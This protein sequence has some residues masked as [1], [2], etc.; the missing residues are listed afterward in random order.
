M[1]TRTTVESTFL[2]ADSD[3]LTVSPGEERTPKASET[4][5][6][7]KLLGS[8]SGTTIPVK[9]PSSHRSSF[10][11]SVK[12]I[13]QESASILVFQAS[14]AGLFC[15]LIQEKKDR[16]L[17]VAMA[18]SREVDFTR[19][20][21]EILSKL[22]KQCRRLPAK[23]LL[24]T[25]N[26][27]TRLVELPVSPLRPRSQKEMRELIHWELETILGEQSRQWMIGNILV[28]RGYLSPGE[29]DDVL[30][31]LNRRQQSGNS[32]L[33]RFG[34]VAIE[35]GYIS[36]EQFRECMKLQSKLV[37]DDDEVAYSWSSPQASSG[38]GARV[39]LSDEI[40]QDRAADADSAYKWLVSGISQSVRQRWSGAFSLN[41]LKLVALY[42]VV[43]TGYACVCIAQ[44]E[45]A[46]IAV[47]EVHSQH[48]VLL[49]GTK[50]RLE[51]LAVQDRRAATVQLDECLALL[52]Q[53]PAAVKEV[54]LF[55]SVA[56]CDELDL[57]LSDWLDVPL[58]RVQA[59]T[60]DV[61]G[62]RALP[63]LGVVSHYLG[64]TASGLVSHIKPND[65]ENNR[66]RRLISP[67]RLIAGCIGLGAMGLIAGVG[68][69][70]F[71]TERLRKE[72]K[73]LRVQVSNDRQLRSEY[74]RI[75]LERSELAAEISEREALLAIYE[76]LVQ[77]MEM[78]LPRARLAV[79]GV[80]KG[81]VISATEGVQLRRLIRKKDVL[82]IEAWALS[83]TEG[84]EFVDMLNQWLKPVGY[85]VRTSEVVKRES[86]LGEERRRRN[87]SRE[88]SALP[89]KIEVILEPFSGERFTL[90]AE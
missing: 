83:D 49:V 31:Q 84:F 26:V 87:F 77:R 81:I 50:T 89:Y 60:G 27:L 16:C 22:K 40:L 3:I 55:T 13:F 62:E 82:Q 36:S 6:S 69:L 7:L 12:N 33:V 48:L 37:T 54:H 58:H 71:E 64:R 21:S 90:V 67:R 65:P 44:P 39:Q 29:R 43:G 17:F 47:L 61:G 10:L 28:E 15:G 52:D 8:S 56:D 42:P 14:A 2:P 68:W 5:R 72:K 18:E 34:D 45:T 4:D 20:I 9:P 19:A 66:W 74:Q 76:G 59:S 25:P 80:M 57:M 53:L 70:H 88:R 79:P 30:E 24:I 78:S 73:A 85:Q 46:S 35:S 86:Q 11:D 51:T 75:R 41:G 23:A 32:A 63:M 1:R 38:A